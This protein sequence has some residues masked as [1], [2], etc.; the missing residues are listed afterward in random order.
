MLETVEMTR[1]PVVPA[2]ALDFSAYLLASSPP[3][4]DF[5]A[6]SRKFSFKSEN[7]M[8]CQNV[9]KSQDISDQTI[10][11]SK[12]TEFSKKNG[13]NVECSRV[14][15]SCKVR[16]GKKR[17]CFAD[18]LGF[19]LVSIRVVKE[20]SDSPPMLRKS[21]LASL[22]V[23]ENACTESTAAFVLNFS[24]P[25]ADYLKFRESLDRN[26]VCLE[27]VILRNSTV[28]GTVKVVN[29]GYDKKIV[30]R[31]TVDDWS[32]I[33]EVSASYVQAGQTGPNN[34]YDTFSF[35]FSVPKDIKKTAKVIFCICY[36]V[37]NQQYWDNN[38]N[39]NYEILPAEV[40]TVQV[41][42]SQLS[43]SDNQKSWSQYSAWSNMDSTV[44][45]W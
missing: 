19:D 13:V 43:I 38:D 34:I 32:T 11:E 24:Q 30:L 15:Q 8:D 40:P 22:T 23:A 36:E 7:S 17:V 29:L 25:A 10:E 44:P 26:K 41:N 28:E 1:T 14:I 27:N 2:S 39:K 45:Y 4:L 3:G 16:D 37:N 33:Q 35:E 9:P 21:L 18:D 6:L 20:S 5:L 31:Y 42:M 12:C